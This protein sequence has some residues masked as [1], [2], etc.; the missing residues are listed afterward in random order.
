MYVVGAILYQSAKDRD[1][2]INMTNP[3]GVGPRGVDH[4]H[5]L[6]GGAI[7][8]RDTC[9]VGRS[10]PASSSR[11]GPC[12][13]CDWRRATPYPTRWTSVADVELPRRQSVPSPSLSATSTPS[14]AAKPSMSRPES[15][16]MPR[17]AE[18]VP[19]EELA[20]DERVA[21]PEGRRVARRRLR[22]HRRVVVVEQLVNHSREL[23]EVDCCVTGSVAATHES[24][25]STSN[26]EWR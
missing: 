16:S 1:A 12:C 20:P 10:G 25:E 14:D 17:R 7:R 6:G 24:P 13:R 2:K 11:T 18:R 9:T 3:V 22:P 4:P 21:R 8:D 15:D 5:V 19:T 26:T 23:L